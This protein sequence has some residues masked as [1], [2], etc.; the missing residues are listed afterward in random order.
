MNWSWAFQSQIRSLRH[1]IHNL[2]AA[3][4]HKWLRLT[5]PGTFKHWTV[6]LGKMRKR[7]ASKLLTMQIC[8]N[9][10]QT[11][12]CLLW[13]TLPCM[14]GLA[15][16]V[17]GPIRVYKSILRSKESESCINRTA[18]RSQTPGIGACKPRRFSITRRKMFT[19]VNQALL[20]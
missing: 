19:I 5:F 3:S 15:C 7:Y 8:E 14:N 2:Y 20:A 16:R 1:A 10:N 12:I 13:S 18:E 6:E 11:R 17:P 4:R 9:K